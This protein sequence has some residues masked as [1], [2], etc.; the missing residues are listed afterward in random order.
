MCHKT[1]NIAKVKNG[2]LTKCETCNKYHLIYN[3][4]F[5][6]FYPI[7][8][9]SFKKYVLQLEVDLWENKNLGIKM[10]RKIPIPTSQENLVIMFDRQEIEE[11]KSLILSENTNKYKFS[12]FDAIDYCSSI[13]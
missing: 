13:N 3:N 5:F 8:F 11:L 10:T 4:I 9:K 2:Q 1:K 12:K 7:E 6:E